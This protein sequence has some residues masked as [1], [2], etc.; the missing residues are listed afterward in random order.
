M[1]GEREC[2]RIDGDVTAHGDANQ[3]WQASHAPS[4]AETCENGGFRGQSPRAIL[5]APPL[6]PFTVYSGN[7]GLVNVHGIL[8]VIR[9][10]IVHM[11]TASDQVHP[12]PSA[13]AHVT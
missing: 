2:A 4:D 9:A 7:A 8:V 12:W 6:F 3:K 1:G 10:P 11:A 5:T 13:F